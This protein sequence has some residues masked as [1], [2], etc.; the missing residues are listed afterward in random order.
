MKTKCIYR[1]PPVDMHLNAFFLDMLLD[2][3]KQLSLF[4][5]KNCNLK[6]SIETVLNVLELIL[7]Q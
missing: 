3:V 2:I 6:I 5:T 1:P 7:S 4:D